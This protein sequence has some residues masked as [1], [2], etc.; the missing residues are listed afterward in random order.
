MSTRIIVIASAIILLA[1]ILFFATTK[2]NPINMLFGGYSSNPIPYRFYARGTPKIVFGTPGQFDVQNVNNQSIAFIKNF[3]EQSIARTPI[4]IHHYGDNLLG[5]AFTL[6]KPLNTNANPNVVPLLMSGWWGQGSA[7]KDFKNVSYYNSIIPFLYNDQKVI[8]S[9]KGSNAYQR[10]QLL[11]RELVRC[12][13]WF[14]STWNDGYIEAKEQ[15][16]NIFPGTKDTNLLPSSGFGNIMNENEKKLVNDTETF[17][18]KSKKEMNRVIQLPLSY[19]IQKM[20]T[21]AK[22]S[23]DMVCPTWATNQINYSELFQE[24]P[25]EG[26]KWGCILGFTPSSGRAWADI[27]EHLLQVS[28]KN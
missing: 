24:E 20:P 23:V 22:I 19:D 16:K 25:P 7:N 12:P 26:F 2:T 5:F 18:L 9:K 14:H 21:K 13:D 17:V 11:N 6:V 3:Y 8:L 27:P 1:L 28:P 15:Y 4:T 10:A